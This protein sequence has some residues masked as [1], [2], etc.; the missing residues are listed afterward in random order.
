M[1]GVT[2]PSR[3]LVKFA[4]WALKLMMTTKPAVVA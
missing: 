4:V 2:T 1:N 3:S